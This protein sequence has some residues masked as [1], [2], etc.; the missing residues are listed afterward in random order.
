MQRPTVVHQRRS[1]SILQAQSVCKRQIYI[2]RLMAL[3]LPDTYK[4]QHIYCPQIT[5]PKDSSRITHTTT[6]ASYQLGI[7]S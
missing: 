7:A 3:V 5:E 4:T 1:I 6:L 2:Y